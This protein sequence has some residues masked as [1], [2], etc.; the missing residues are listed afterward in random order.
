[1][2]RPKLIRQ[3]F[4]P[5]LLVL[6]LSLL[7]FIGYASYTFRNFHL[8]QTALEL[9]SRARLLENQVLP[10]LLPLQ[11]EKLD[12]L[13]KTIGKAS[14]TRVTLVLPSGKVVGDSVENPEKMESHSTRQEILE[15]KQGRTGRSIR[16]SRTLENNMIYTAIPLYQGENKL[17]AVLRTAIPLTSL[18]RQLATLWIHLAFAGILVSLLAG[19]MSLW[20]AKRISRPME[21]MKAGAMRFAQGQLGKMPVPETEELASLAEAMNE[22]AKEL[23]KRFHTII[24]Q[25]NELETVLAS[26]VEGVMAIDP[27]E[28]V[29]SMNASAAKMFELDPEEGQGRNIQELI[30][31]SAF[32]KFIKKALAS[33]DILQEDITFYAGEERILSVRNSPLLNPGN[34][35]TGTLVVIDDVTKLR[36]LENIRKDFVAN[37]SHEIRT[38]LTTIKGFVETLYHE[39]SPDPEKSRHFLEII[40]KHVDRL[41][42]IIEDLLSL[43]KIER[44]K[45]KEEILFSNGDVVEVIQTAMGICRPKADRKNIRINLL[46][47][48]PLPVSMDKTLLEQAIVNILDNA[49]NYSPENTAIE[50]KTQVVGTDI[51]IRVRDQGIGIPKEHVPRLFERFY[52]VDKARSRKLGGTGLGLA[53]VKHIM[54]AHKG[55]VSA[56]STPGKG[57]EFTLQ[58][59]RTR[60]ENPSK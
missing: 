21:E 54:E 25:K 41:S 27:A 23:E 20:I 40:L 26:M 51:L 52:R 36:R 42:A 48:E 3:I 14:S 32:Q 46:A 30:R 9:E 22:M 24:Q 47:G 44:E 55:T 28:R 12:A 45:E 60:Q 10:L 38:P 6:L 1:M 33:L 31:N 11:P 13:C 17:V 15:A 5:Y 18:D 53:I 2:T 58:F 37:A 16:Y 29:L 8:D 50:V 39:S 49:V 57:S 7:C 34:H 43:S 59:P 35:V 19:A 4:P 56:V